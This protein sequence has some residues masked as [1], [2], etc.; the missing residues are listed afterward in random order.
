MDNCIKLLEAGKLYVI[1]HIKKRCM[2]E[3][4]KFLYPTNVLAIYQSAEDL[5]MPKLKNTCTKYMVEKLEEVCTLMLYRVQLA[6][7]EVQTHNFRG[8]RH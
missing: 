1:P 6:M 2:E 5:D 3:I 4:S 7:N 8:D